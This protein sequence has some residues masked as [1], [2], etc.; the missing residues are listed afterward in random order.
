MNLNNNDIDYEPVIIALSNGTFTRYQISL[1]LASYPS[2]FCQS[3][4]YLTGSKSKV[5]LV[6]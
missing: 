3:T 1:N 4:P 5:I 2:T 6:T